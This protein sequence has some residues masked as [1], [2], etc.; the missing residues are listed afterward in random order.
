MCACVCMC[1][2]LRMCV[3][4]CVF[5]FV[6]VFVHVCLEDLI[7]SQSPFFSHNW[8]TP[9]GDNKKRRQGVIASLKFH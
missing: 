4:V 6:F 9:C 1:A 7:H 8:G 3:C 5:V 2:C